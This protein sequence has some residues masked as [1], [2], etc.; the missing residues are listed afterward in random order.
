MKIFLALI[1]FSLSASASY[2]IPDGGVTT[3]KLASGAVTQA[4]RAALGQQLS[5]SSST[6]AST[7]TSIV[8]VTNLT[9]TITTTGRPVFVGLIQDASANAGFVEASR[10]A[11]TSSSS[12]YFY[13]DGSNIAAS[14]LLS[15]TFN[16]GGYSFVAVPS[17]SYYTIDAPASGSHTYKFRCK[18]NISGFNAASS[19]FY[20]KLIAY[21]L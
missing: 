16:S 1:L 13:R 20:T 10:E 2:I 12:F 18:V 14:T 3:A 4:K 17:S 11:E 7:S 6:F 9:V 19:V 5:S 15:N 21:E 8:D